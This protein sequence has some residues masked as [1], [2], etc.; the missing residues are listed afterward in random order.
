MWREDRGR[1]RICEAESDRRVRRQKRREIGNMS[2]ASLS[3]K[4]RLLQKLL[5]RVRPASVASFMKA[6]FRIKRVVLETKD[7]SFYID[8]VTVFAAILTDSGEYDPD[9][10]QILE[11]ILKPSGVFIDVGANEGYFSVIGARL[12]EKHGKV[13]AVEPQ[14]R[15]KPVLEKNFQLNCVDNVLLVDKAISNEIGVA[16]IYISPTTNPGSTSLHQSTSYKLPTEHIATITLSELFRIAKIECTDLLKMDIE[17][18]EYEAILGSPELFRERKIKY[19]ALELHSEM[20][21]K[22]GLDPKEIAAFLRQCGYEM[23]PRFP[24]PVWTVTA[25]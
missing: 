2:K 18:F 24:I 22:R 15:L 9:L 12:V 25:A 14:K 11:S 6:V 5:M 17:G 19:L 3:F 8:P 21:E 23:D 20:I 16:T 4:N 10:K 13:V 1:D 7:G